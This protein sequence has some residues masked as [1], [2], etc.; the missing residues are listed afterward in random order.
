MKIIFEKIE[1]TISVKTATPEYLNRQSGEQ[2]EKDILIELANRQVPTGVRYKII[3]DTDLPSDRDF[4]NAW[5][6]DFTTDFDGVGA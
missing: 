2:N 6:Y 3:E 1:G 5:E 4:R